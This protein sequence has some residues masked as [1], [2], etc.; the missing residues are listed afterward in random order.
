MGTFLGNLRS[1]VRRASSLLVL[2]PPVVIL[3]RSG[4]IWIGWHVRGVSRSRIFRV[5]LEI[6]VEPCL[7]ISRHELLILRRLA[8]FCLKMIKNSLVKRLLKY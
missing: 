7:A 3:L 6:L 4:S 1:G 2:L 8:L 5:L